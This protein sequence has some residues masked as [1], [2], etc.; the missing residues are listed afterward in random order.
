MDRK[1]RRYCPV[2]NNLL[3]ANLY[4]KSCYETV[5]EKE[6]KELERFTTTYNLFF[7]AL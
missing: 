6:F 2:C 1:E 7:L 4:C 5:D 3:D